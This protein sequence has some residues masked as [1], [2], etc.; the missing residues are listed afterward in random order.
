[1]PDLTVW[2]TDGADGSVSSEARWR[3]M[4]RGWMPSGVDDAAGGFGSLAATLVAGPTINVAAGA[5][6]LDGHYAEL[7]TPTSVPATANGLLVVR[8]TPAD[9]HAELLWRDAA[10]APTQTLATWELVL[11]QMTA[12]VI[13]DRRQF[14]RYGGLFPMPACILRSTAA[15]SMPSGTSVVQFTAGVSNEVVDT[16]GMHDPA[17]SPNRITAPMRG[18]YAC[19]AWAAW[20]STAGVSTNYRHMAIANQAGGTLANGRI[21]MANATAS[22]SENT[23]AVDYVFAP[24]DYINLIVIQDSGVALNLASVQLSMI[25]LGPAPWGTGM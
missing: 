14:A 9:N 5:C 13:G 21:P 22:P 8:F 24:G 12:G 4:A 15:Q 11:A 25:Y 6:W 23:V 18:I 17:V 10:V 20:A 2:P 1:M 3:K 7:V 16:H 19:K